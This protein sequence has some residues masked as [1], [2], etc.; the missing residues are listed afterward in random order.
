MDE[1]WR[2]FLVSGRVTDYLKCKEKEDRGESRWERSDGA[3][4][5]GDRNGLKCNADWRV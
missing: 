2:D 5:S 1:A 4:C 3:E